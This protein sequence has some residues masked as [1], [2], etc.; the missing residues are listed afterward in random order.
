[1]ITSRVE[2]SPRYAYLKWLGSGFCSNCGGRSTEGI[3]VWV[4]SPN[5]TYYFLLFGWKESIHF[6]YSSTSSLNS[7]LAFCTRLAFKG[8]VKPLY[9]GTITSTASIIK[10]V[11]LSTGCLTVLNMLNLTSSSCTLSFSSPFYTSIIALLVARNGLS[12]RMGISLSSSMSNTMKSVG[13]INLSTFTSTSS[14][15]P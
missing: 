4:F 14:I 7:S 2:D 12:S 15:T 9:L 1:M 8:L 10:H 11:S 3:E 13:M 6:T 5:D